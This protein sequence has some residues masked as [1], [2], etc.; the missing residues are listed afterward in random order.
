VSVVRRRNDRGTQGLSTI[1]KQRFL[2]AFGSVMGFFIFT[3]E[4]RK[5]K[6]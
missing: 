2:W 4:V 1:K 5:L 6:R 3:I